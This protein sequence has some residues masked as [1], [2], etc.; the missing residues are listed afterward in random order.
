[1]SLLWW[2]ANP[3]IIKHTKSH[4]STKTAFYSI[5]LADPT[6]IHRGKH[7]PVDGEAQNAKLKQQMRLYHIV[8]DIKI[9]NERGR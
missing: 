2:G 3:F 4:I 8:E 7:V 9:E 1:M 6:D 5:L